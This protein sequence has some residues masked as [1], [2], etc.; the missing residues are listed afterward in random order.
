MHLSM[1]NK[2]EEKTN[3]IIS[4]TLTNAPLT[5][6]DKTLH[7]TFSQGRFVPSVKPLMDGNEGNVDET[8][9]DIVTIAGN[10]AGEALPLIS[11]GEVSFIL[12]GKKYKAVKSISESSGEAQIVLVKRSGKL[13]CL[14]VYYPNFHFKDDILNAVWNLKADMVMTLYDYGHTTV[15]GVER[16]YE[17]MEY[18]EGGTLSQLHFDGD[19]NQFRL[20]ALQAA[21][22]LQA[23]HSF[24]IIHKDIKPANYFFRDKEHKQLVLGDFGISTMMKEGEELMRTSQARTPAF[25]APEMYDDVIDGE[26]EI[27][28]R[29]DFYSL[30]ITL[31]Y[32]WLGKSP[33][34][35]NERLMMRLKQEGRLPFIDD[36]PE[37]VGMIVKGLTCVNPKRRWGY[38][39][40][41]RW[42]LGEDVPID[43]SSV[44]L[45]Y[46]A[47]M[48]DPERNL[49]AHDLK[50]LV[51][52][53]YDN[54]KLG[55]RYLY[56]NRIAAWLDECGNN[57]MAVLLNDI[58]EH[59]YP[60]NQNAGLMAALYAME[61]DFPYYDIRGKACHSAQEIALSLLNNAQD[62]QYKLQDPFDTL[63][64]YLDSHFS[65][66]LERL[67]SYFNP[68][69]NKS[70][71]KLAYEIDST[72]PFLTSVEYDSLSD[73]VHAFS[74]P[75]RTEDE[76][77]SLTNGCLLAWL[78][79]HAEISLCEGIKFLTSHQLF[80]KRTTAYQ[81]L[82]NLDRNCAF[83]LQQANTIGK[84][85]DLMAERLCQCQ[86]MEEEDFKRE[87][88]DFISLGGRLEVYAQLHKWNETLHAMHEILD[89]NSAGNT[90]R[91]GMYDT[92]TAAYKLCKAMG[93]MPLFEFHGED[94]HATVQHPDELNSLPIKDVRM[95]LRSGYLMQWISI[96]FHEDPTANF[97]NENEYNGCVRDFLQTIGT[98][99][100]GEIHYK[101]YM[102]AQ[103]QLDK[104]VHES[105][106][107][108]NQSMKSKNAFRIAFVV[109]NLLWL[110]LLMAF[111]LEETDNMKN[112]VFMYTMLSV[113]IPFGSMLAVRNYFRGN[114][115]LLG[116]LFVVLG[117]LLSIIPAFILSM[118]LGT[119]GMARWAA[120]GMSLLYMG[121]GLKYAFGKGTV[122]SSAS[123]LKEAFDVDERNALS[124]IL[125]YTFRTRSFKFKGSNFSLMDDAVGEV[126]SNSTEK[127]INCVMWSLVP[128]CL[129]LS[130]LWFHSSFLDHGGPDVDSWRQSLGE[131]WT[132]FKALFQ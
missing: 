5:E 44:Y 3:T 45:R 117:V 27:D 131:F 82:Y 33:F 126:Q 97:S 47:F 28:T 46:K 73:I 17:L 38:E 122:G 15:N 100:G 81:V 26:V 92:R 90:G 83:D 105:H 10:T 129:I 32:L 35:K 111:G 132:H 121:V 50:E 127:V 118:C 29:V 6:A 128:A 59:K 86:D 120:L 30:G 69:D 84:V 56:S 43:T 108:W 71:L 16:D 39:E 65:V 130:M 63:Y 21:A 24:G 42:F 58:V 1:T 87:M 66:N 75:E 74:S 41:E 64:V 79:G 13:Y 104:K 52:L 18:L 103:E 78:Y 55:I 114:G 25:A 110:L 62:Y 68:A 4:P 88:S 19:F 60:S 80:D 2:T 91:Y 124:E 85:A 40:V 57:K 116:L 93:G 119:A 9:D 109:I 34:A 7:G 107:A 12:K 20:I 37:R 106:H 77:D 70:V 22:A 125:Y 31:M 123:E 48:I 96:F 49:A 98:F 72:L 94:Y 99:D 8:S 113:G 67:R 61:P 53:L 112:H 36:L 76:W 115:F 54:Q 95:A 101:R 14:K 51:P 11:A 89:V 23:C 102:I